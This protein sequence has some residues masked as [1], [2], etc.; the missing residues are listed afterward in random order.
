MK[1]IPSERDCFKKR[2]QIFRRLV[3]LMALKAI[4]LENT[5]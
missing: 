1:I 5:M 4:L 3:V 2:M